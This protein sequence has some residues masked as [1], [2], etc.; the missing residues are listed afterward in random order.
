MSDYIHQELHQ[1][2]TAIGGE[3]ILVKEVR[4]PFEGREILYIVGHAVFDSTCCGVSGCAY[5]LVPGF[6]L[7]WRARHNTTGLPVSRVEPVQSE[8][9]RA[10]LRKLIF[11]REIVHQVQFL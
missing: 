8:A 2:I 1:E 9:D 11:E 10:R 4:L 7:D 6:I 3:Y 5:A